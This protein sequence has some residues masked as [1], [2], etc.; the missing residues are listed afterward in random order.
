MAGL[1]ARHRDDAGA[2][3]PRSASL[4]PGQ[5]YAPE[6]ALAPDLGPTR[7]RPVCV[8]HMF[9]P[10]LG[11]PTRECPERGHTLAADV[12]PTRRLGCSGHTLAADLGGGTQ[13]RARAPDVCP[14]A[15]AAA[16]LSTGSAG[17]ST[18]TAPRGVRLQVQLHHTPRETAFC[19]LFSSK[20]AGPGTDGSSDLA[21]FRR[22]YGTRTSEDL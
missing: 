5:V 20:L 6:H 21:G 15:V 17:Y 9:A 18:V 2:S 11:G 4:G 19:Q 7:E 8:G 14:T 16:H 10:N 12:G 3:C 1:L 13:R 22:I